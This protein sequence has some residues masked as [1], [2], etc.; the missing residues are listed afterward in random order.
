MQHKFPPSTAAAHALTI[1]FRSPNIV[2]KKGIPAFA[3]DSKTR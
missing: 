1:R 3:S 2:I